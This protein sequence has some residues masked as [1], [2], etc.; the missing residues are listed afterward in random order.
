[1]FTVRDVYSEF[2]LAV[3]CNKITEVTVLAAMKRARRAYR[4]TEERYILDYA[5]QRW[6]HS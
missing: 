3:V 5:D 2:Y 4:T 6:S 1:M